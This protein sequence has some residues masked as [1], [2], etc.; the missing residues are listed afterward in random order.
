MLT[1][2]A[3]IK[4]VNE[5]LESYKALAMS[6]TIVLCPPAMA[7]ADLSRELANTPIKLGAQ[8]CGAAAAGAFTGEIS[9]AD[10]VEYDATYCLVGHSERRTL[11]HETDELVATKA[12]VLIQH[13]ITPVICIGE[14]LAEYQSNQTLATLERQISYVLERL[15][16]AHV[17][18]D[19]AS[20]APQ[21]ERGM[22]ALSFSPDSPENHLNPAHP[23]EGCKP[24]SKDMSVKNSILIAYEPVWAIGSGLVPNKDQ[25]NNIFSSL[26]KIIEKKSPNLRYKL[27][28]GGSVSSKSIEMLGRVEPLD[29]FLVGGA[30]LDFQEFKKIVDYFN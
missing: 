9:A 13:R 15:D 4:L 26:A 25:L 19:A 1:S 24:V 7:L 20:A 8:T 30:S 22:Q 10:L 27:L 29:G 14:T 17:L 28:Y 2:S 18:R 16:S 3:V 23:E 11:F 21:D 12:N 5:N 6:H